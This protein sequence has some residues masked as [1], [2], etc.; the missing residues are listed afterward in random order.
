[1]EDI[2]QYAQQ[3]AAKKAGNTNQENSQTQQGT[4]QNVQ[5]Q[6]G[7][8]IN[9]KNS[10]INSNSDNSGEVDP[11]ERLFRE[12]FGGDPKKL[13]QAYRNSQREFT[14][15]QSSLK[16]YEKYKQV[17]D[18][19]N[20]VSAKDPMIQEILEAAARGE[21]VE[22][23]VQKKW[24]PE[25][26]SVLSDS[27]KLNGDITSAD[28]NTLVGS[29]YLDLA[30][31]AGLTA[32]EW[33]NEV[34]RAQL[35]Y[36]TTEIPKI[37]ADRTMAEIQRRQ[38]EAEDSQTKQQLAKTNKQRFERQFDDAIQAGY[39]FAGEHKDIYEQAV[40]EM[41]YMVDPSN[42]KLIREDSF[43]LA[44][45][46]ISMRNGK[47][48]KQVVQPLPKNQQSVNYNGRNVFSGGQAPQVKLSGLDAVK[49]KIFDTNQRQINSRLP[50]TNR[51]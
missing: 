1:M 43:L 8:D 25:G 20:S 14:K 4:E 48:P 51:R 26:K 5:S 12:T 15:T 35:R 24:K 40:R 44:L 18:G 17:V 31:K 6:E 37:T 33:Q 42:P 39:D 21:S 46:A 13:A 30:K 19:I 32:T 50:Q 9:Q 10:Y 28:E 3:L 36:A 16:E 41:Q 45:S 47:Q 29:G 2:E 22:N 34:M 11:D 23:Y 49:A 38:K 7:I 27:G